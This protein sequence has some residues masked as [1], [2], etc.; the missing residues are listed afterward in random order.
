[1]RPIRIRE[2]WWTFAYPMSRRAPFLCVSFKLDEDEQILA[3]TRL[4][5]TLR[6][7]WGLANKSFAI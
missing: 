5:L 6:A 4:A 2:V 3:G 7:H 1:M